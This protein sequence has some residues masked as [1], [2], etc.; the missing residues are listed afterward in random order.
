MELSRRHALRLGA[1]TAGLGVTGSLAG[2]SSVPFVGGSDYTAWLPEP[3]TIRDGLD[4]YDFRQM[5]AAEVRTKED[6]FDGHTYASYEERGDSTLDLVGLDFDDAN[7]FLAYQG[8]TVVDAS[9]ERA[10]VADELG[11]EEFE[12][13]T[14]HEGYTVY[15]DANEYR[16]VA[17]SGGT[18]VFGRRG[19]DTDAVDVVERA[20]DTKKGDEDRYTEANEDFD[21]LVST[22]DT[23]TFTR[24][25]GFEDGD[26]AAQGRSVS[27]HESTTTVEV[28]VVYEDADAVDAEEVTAIEDQDED[29]DDIRRLSAN[30]NGRVV[31]VSW[32]TDTDILGTDEY[33]GVGFAFGR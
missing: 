21:L 25:T 23:G 12:E 15:T 13:A 4:A 19:G 22:L 27:V 28:V 17:V 32:D 7:R 5:D 20:I 18:I 30:K 8:I 2:C 6:N 33:D 10:E 11:D 14:D 9:Y 24:G 29:R 16:A 1:A 26:R 31:T 3:G